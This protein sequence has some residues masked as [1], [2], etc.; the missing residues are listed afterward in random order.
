MYLAV[1]L[2]VGIRKG[3]TISS[4]IFNINNLHYVLVSPLVS[5]TVKY[6]TY[7]FFERERE[8]ER[9]GGEGQRER[10]RERERILSRLHAQCG[11]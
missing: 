5:G 11:A 7:F 1:C 6:I 9:E 4:C 8:R 10:E 3:T 2:T